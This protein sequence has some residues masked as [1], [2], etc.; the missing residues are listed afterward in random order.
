MESSN[1]QHCSTN[2]SIDINIDVDF[3]INIDL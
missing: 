1:S 2:L 3:I